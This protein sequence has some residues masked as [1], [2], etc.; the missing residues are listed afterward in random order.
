MKRSPDKLLCL[1]CAQKILIAKTQMELE[2][3]AKYCLELLHCILYVSY[4]KVCIF[5]IVIS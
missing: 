3:H 1:H 4:P 2:I 5:V